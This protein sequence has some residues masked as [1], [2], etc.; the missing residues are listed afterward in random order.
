MNYRIP[1][2]AKKYTEYDMIQKHTELPD[3][4]DFRTRLLFAFLN[5]HDRLKATSELYALVTSLVQLGLDTH[6]MVADTNDAKEKKAA[7]SRQLKVLAGDYFSSRFYHLLSQ[8]GQ[9][10]LIRVLSGA[11]CEVNRL[12][13]NLYM[14]MKQLKV[15]AED[16]IQQ[17]VAI[18]S[19][20]FLS[21]GSM[22]EE[23]YQSVWPEVLSCFTRCEVLFEE[24]FK[25]ESVERFRGSWGYWH[26]MQHGTKEDRK[27]LQSGDVDAGKLRMLVLK[28][29]VPVHLHQLLEAALAQL[30]AKVGLIDSDKLTD[31]LF[32]CSEPFVRL[33]NKP[34]VL[35]EI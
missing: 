22:M 25:A 18:R 26:I 7:R 1:E 11:I 33:L 32:S 20:L 28:H 5:R 10:E 3:F 9:I 13:M 29:N 19:R 27:A 35:E 8:A 2:I 31:E 24:L 6:D 30:H 4:P 34:K 21:F 14:M 17:S 12:K 15:T 16:Y 23:V